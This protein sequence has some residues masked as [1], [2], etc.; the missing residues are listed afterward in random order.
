MGFALLY[1]S[2]ASSELLLDVLERDPLADVFCAMPRIPLETNPLTQRAQ[3]DAEGFRRL[4]D[5]RA[6]L[7]TS[8]LKA[9][10]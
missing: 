8:A 9:F 10:F 4:C 5:L 2:Y 7:A 3:R 1:P 6:S